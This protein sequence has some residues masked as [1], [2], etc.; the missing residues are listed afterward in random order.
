LNSDERSVVAAA[1]AAATRSR[2]PASDQTAH[3]PSHP[4]SGGAFPLRLNAASAP[5]WL[6]TA[7][8][9]L[10]SLIFEPDSVRHSALLGMLPFAAVLAIAAMG[11]TLVVQQGGID[12]S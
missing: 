9:F 7:P 6:A 5:I 12:L 1:A 3:T 8:L 4:S 11:Q 10:V 2:M